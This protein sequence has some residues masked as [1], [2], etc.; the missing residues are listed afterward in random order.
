MKVSFDIDTYKTR[1]LGG[2]RAYLFYALLQFP[3]AVTKSIKPSQSAKSWFTPFGQGS[4][5]DFVP[6]LVKS[7]SIPETSFEEA[8]IPFPGH[9]FK[10]AAGARN[11]GNW[12][13]SF[14][15]DE[16]TKIL[17]LFNSWHNIIYNPVT[18]KSSEPAVYMK[19]QQL[20][21][22]N[23][24]GEA[25]RK[26]T[27]YNAWPVAIGATSLDYSSTEIATVDVTFSYQYYLT[28]EMEEQDSSLLKS[29]FGKIVGS[30]ISILGR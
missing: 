18:Q 8:V 23:G 22:I 24:S 9:S 16:K 5:S 11:Y 26:F 1:F 19:E 21:L 3:S 30:P 29:L 28:S 2:A 12:S 17:D 6:Y 10:M 14:N 13:I 20:Y 7:T 25:T 15:I 27:L 4:A